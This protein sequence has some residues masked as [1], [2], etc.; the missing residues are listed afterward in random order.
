MDCEAFLACSLTEAP[1]SGGH[2]RIMSDVAL[3]NHLR[4]LVSWETGFDALGGRCL[5]APV[6]GQRRPDYN[7]GH[8]GRECPGVLPSGIF[9]LVDTV[10][11]PDQ[12]G[13]PQAAISRRLQCRRRADL[14]LHPVSLGLANV[15]PRYRLTAVLSDAVLRPL[16]FEVAAVRSKVE[17]YIPWCRR[18][19]SL[20]SRIG[21]KA[22]FG[23]YHPTNVYL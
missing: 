23:I 21:I 1:V 6:V 2:V 14:K 20:I 12:E 13:K 10:L 5:G 4:R 22:V 8:E 11:G 15:G 17:Q 16:P 18:H 9:D 19:E 7:R 3:A